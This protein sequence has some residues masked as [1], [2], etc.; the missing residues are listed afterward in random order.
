MAYSRCGNCGSDMA[1]KI[2]SRLFVVGLL[3]AATPAV[4]AFVPYL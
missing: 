3:M 4:P 2:P 1:R